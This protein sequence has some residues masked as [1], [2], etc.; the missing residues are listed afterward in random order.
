[1]SVSQLNRR[2]LLIASV[3]AASAGNVQA[4]LRVVADVATADLAGGTHNSFRASDIAGG[5]N[6]RTLAWFDLDL[7]NTSTWNEVD[8]SL[9]LHVNVY[10]DSRLTDRI[11]GAYASGF[12]RPG[13][14]SA[15]AFAQDYFSLEAEAINWS[16]QLDG[17]SSF[18]S[19]LSR[20][21]GGQPVDGW[22]FVIGES[23]QTSADSTFSGKTAAPRGGLTH[24]RTQRLSDGPH[25]L[26]LQTN[27]MLKM[28]TATVPLPGSALM[29]LFGFTGLAIRQRFYRP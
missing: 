7:S 17:A 24:D 22:E 1:M 10:S 20:M 27:I 16:V 29:A 9:S 4:D 5:V 3:V 8:Q 28:E 18:E 13:E 21:F 6:D 2:V 11:G 12:V 25:Q 23:A 15:E 14:T 19:F 26:S